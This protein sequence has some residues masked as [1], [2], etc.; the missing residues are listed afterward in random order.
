M[1]GDR[2]NHYDYADV[3]CPFFK[4]RSNIRQTI[5]CEA[6]PNTAE[7]NLMLFSNMPSLEIH[8]AKHCCNGYFDCPVA[9]ALYKKYQE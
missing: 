3:L 7:A 4:R 1:G 2:V 8:F 6:L 9:K 5:T